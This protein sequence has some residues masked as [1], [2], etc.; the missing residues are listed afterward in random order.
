MLVSFEADQLFA[1][2][3]FYQIEAIVVW[4]VMLVVVR[5]Q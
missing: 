1:D 4:L 2:L 3:P 5:F